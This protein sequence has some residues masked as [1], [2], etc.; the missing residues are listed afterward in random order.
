M[1]RDEQLGDRIHGVVGTATGPVAIGKD[2]NQAVGSMQVQ[3]SEAELTELRQAFAGLR[4]QVRAS[5]PLE[6]QG[7]AL[8][9][10]GEL[11]SDTLTER[12]K[13]ATMR[14]VRDWFSEHLPQVAGAVTGLVVHP[15]VGKL[16]EA[17]GEAVA[18]EFKALLGREQT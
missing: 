15:V 11:E 12:P 10:V 6:S 4:A 8:E 3:V 7:R 2:I 5:V 16:V 17:A 14:Y 1:G 18:G 13:P 9:L